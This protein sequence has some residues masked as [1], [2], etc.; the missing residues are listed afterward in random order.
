MVRKAIR[1]KLVYLKNFIT[2]FLL[3]RMRDRDRR[4]LE[5]PNNGNYDKETN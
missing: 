4:I 2:V 1:S 3:I 5:R